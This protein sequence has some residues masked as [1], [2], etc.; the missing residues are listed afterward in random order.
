MPCKNSII[1]G[2]SGIGMM[3]GLGAD[4]QPV[5]VTYGAVIEFVP[6]VKGPF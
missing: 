2:M 6:V 3:F 1:A 4:R 5:P